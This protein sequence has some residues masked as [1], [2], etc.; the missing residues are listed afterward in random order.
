MLT[1]V[2]HYDEL[3]NRIVDRF[4]KANHNLFNPT[5][6]HPEDNQSINLT[7]SGSHHNW[8]ALG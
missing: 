6:I 4:N 8:F 2:P 5:T 3:E 1:D 7:S